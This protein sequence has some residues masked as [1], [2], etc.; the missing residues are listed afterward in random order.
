MITQFGDAARQNY[1]L[2]CTP[3]KPDIFQTRITIKN[4]NQRKM[5]N[6][7]SITNID[8]GFYQ[9]SRNFEIRFHQVLVDLGKEFDRKGLDATCIFN[10]IKFLNPCSSFLNDGINLGVKAKGLRYD[11]IFYGYVA[12]TLAAVQHI[13]NRWQQYINNTGKITARQ[14]DREIRFLENLIPR[15]V[16]GDQIFGSYAKGYTFNLRKCLRG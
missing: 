6:K 7:K 11:G 2:S 16:F 10:C 1:F 15:K 12:V 8:I 9:E 14:I 13:L 4:Q 3:R 5:P